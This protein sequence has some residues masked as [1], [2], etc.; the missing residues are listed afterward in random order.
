[1]SW[2]HI[3]KMVLW[4]IERVAMDADK[5]GKP[6]ILERKNHEVPQ[7]DVKETK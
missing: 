5:D 7:T 3:L 6:D 2:L 1:M 4:I